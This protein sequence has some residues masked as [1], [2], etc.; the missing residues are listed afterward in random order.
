[1]LALKDM[2]IDRRSVLVAGVHAVSV[3]ATLGVV[4]IPGLVLEVSKYF[5]FF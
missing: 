4:S 1:M 5:K 2:V 3:H